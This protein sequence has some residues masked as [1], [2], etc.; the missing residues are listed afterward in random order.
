MINPTRLAISGELF[1]HS[2][3]GK[4]RECVVLWHFRLLTQN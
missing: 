1:K 2:R 4:M 3:D